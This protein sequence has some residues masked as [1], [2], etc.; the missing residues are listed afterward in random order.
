MSDHEFDCWC[1]MDHCKVEM[2]EDGNWYE[3][4]S[5]GENE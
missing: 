2:D 3:I 5:D 1:G 4:D